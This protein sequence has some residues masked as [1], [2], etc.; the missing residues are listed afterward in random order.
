M[1]A[2]S[3]FARTGNPGWSSFD[4]QNKVKMQFDT[5]VDSIGTTNDPMMQARLKLWR[6]IFYSS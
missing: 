4:L 6:G 2:W 3:G 5:P 1:K